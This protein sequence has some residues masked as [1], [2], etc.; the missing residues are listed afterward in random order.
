MQ[1]YFEHPTEEALERFLLHQSPEPEIE[2][3]ETHVLACESCVARL[4]LLETQIAATKMALEELRRELREKEYSREKRSWRAWFAPF[5]LSFAGAVACVALA[6]GLFLPAQVNLSAYRGAETFFAPEWRPLHVH[7]NASDLADGPIA[8]QLVNGEGAEV[9][10]GS[11]TVRNERVDVRLPRVTKS[12]SYFL[13]L[14]EPPK[15]SAEGDLLREY[16]FRT[17]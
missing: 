16:A 15:G 12:G 13:R 9:W 8:I 1:Q 17:R 10:R 3:V 7:L 6:I 4:E 14:Y 11:G 2:T 5:S